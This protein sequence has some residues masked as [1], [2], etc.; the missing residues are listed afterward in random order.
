M[1]KFLTKE[2]K[3][4]KRKRILKSL[5]GY[6]YISPW[7]IGFLTFTAFPLLSSIW[8]SLT[9]WNLF[10]APE[11]VGFAN[12]SKLFSDPLFWQALKVTAKYVFTSVPLRLIIGFTLALLLNNNIPGMGV[13]RTI[14]YLP[15]VTSGVA[16]SL[17]W[18]WIFNPE[19]GILNVILQKF[20]I[21]GPAW[22]MSETWALPA[23]II[24]S[25]WS[26][27][28]SMIIYL[29]GLQNIPSQLYEAVDID[30]GG[31]LAKVWNV[32]LPMMTPIVFYN[33]VM[34]I[35]GSFQVFTDAYVMS[36]GGPHNA[37]LFYVL[38][39]YRNAFQYF[40]M[41]YA[42]ALAWVLFAII[43]GFTLLIFKSSPMWV[44]YEGEMKN[45]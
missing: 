17:L 8:I 11:F 42:S 14:F 3:A 43:L 1:G 7:L 27:G 33:L 15:T 5:E 20:G 18:L 35:I 38:Y 34:G 23:I 40:E 29:A 28:G 26:V 30:G 37:T 24:M 10:S 22:L 16:V 4:S 45:S 2:K 39:L 32:T 19:Y 31:W 41:G 25:L 44:Y 6:V 21:I 36:N 13:Y 12:Y 9:E